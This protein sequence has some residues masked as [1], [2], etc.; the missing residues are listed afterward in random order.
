MKDDSNSPTQT[1]EEI[2]KQDEK[3]TFIYIIVFSI[4]L[5][6]VFIRFKRFYE[7]KVEVMKVRHTDQE[8]RPN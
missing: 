7:T 1:E 5:A 4:F 2:K 8:K 3:T 6:L